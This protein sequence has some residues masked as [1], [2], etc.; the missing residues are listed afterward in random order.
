MIQLAARVGTLYGI[1]GT[2][3][4]RQYRHHLSDYF[5]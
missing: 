2:L 1:D 5:Q 4:E 3:L